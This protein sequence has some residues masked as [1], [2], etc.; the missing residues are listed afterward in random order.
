MASVACIFA[1]A[2]VDVNCSCYSSD[3]SRRDKEAFASLFRVLGIEEHIDYGTFN[4][5]C[6]NLLNE[7]C[8]VRE[9]V[10]DMILKNTSVL[11]VVQ[12]EKCPCQKVLLIDEVDVF[13]SDQYYGGVYT[14][15]VYLKHPLVK[16]LLDNVWEIKTIRTL[17]GIKALPACTACAESFSNWTFLLD[18]AIKDMIAALQSYQSSTYLVKN[19]KIVYVEGES[20]VENVVRGYDTVWAYYHENRKR[21]ISSSSLEANVGIIINCGAFSYAEMPHN[22]AYITGV[23]GTLKTLA[24]AEKEIL[25]KVYTVQKNTYMP[26]V[27][28]SCNR[29]YNCET[30]ICVVNETEYFMKIRGE[31]DAML[32]AKRA[33]LVFF[34]SEEKLHKFYDSSE[35]FSIRPDVQLITE[36]VDVKD[37]ELCVRRAATIGKVTLLTRTFGRGTDFICNNQGLLAKGGIH[38]LQTFFSEELSEQY[39]IMGRGARHGDLGLY[40]M[41]L[42]DKDLEWVLGA[43]WTTEL[44]KI[45]GRTLYEN[46]NKARNDIFQ[47]KCNSKGVGIV[48][49]KKEHEASKNFM[50]VLN[51]GDIV[52]VKEFLKFKT[53]EQI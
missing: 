10:R 18:E 30:D 38:V 23:T 33:I 15:V 25:A 43:S 29:L 5:L 27:F 41:V 13:L 7:Q 6:E 31:I 50:K 20:I 44:P 28:G 37:R 35:L 11:E 34:E 40:R 1:L 51:G 21:E 42:L 4:K 14:P 53:K 48:Q 8:N 24:E 22:F 36:K 17:N 49:R 45:A 52:T 12:E 3:L 16:A 46:L 9:K 2:G 47:S 26:S 39:Q 19:D 32:N